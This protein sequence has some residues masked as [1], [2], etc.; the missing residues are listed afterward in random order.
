MRNMEHARVILSMAARNLA[1]N[2]GRTV[3]TLVAITVGLLG[4][5]LLD[6][7]IT[8][9]MNGFRDAIIRSGTGH[10]EVAGAPAYFDA[11]DTNP[12]PFLL[13]NEKAVDAQLRS[14]PGVKDVMPVMTFSAALSDAGT[15]SFVQVAAYPTAQARTLL[16]LRTIAAGSD[17]AP[18]QSG[19]IL[20]G[21]GLARKLNLSP[22]RTVSL[23]ALSK[24]GG[25]NTESYTVV[26]TSSSG[27]AEVDNVSVSMSLADAQSLVGVQTVASLI[28]FLENTDETAAVAGRISRAPLGTALAGLAERTWEQLSPSFR[29]A[30]SLYQLILFVARFIV[31]LVALFSISGT[32]AVSVMERFRELGT[33]R[34]FGTRRGQ[35]L[36]LLMT[37]ALLLGLAGA[38]AGFLAGGGVSGLVNSLGGVPMPPE[39]GMSTSSITI[40]LTPRLSSFFGN[41]LWLLAASLAAALVPGMSAVRKTVRRALEI[42][43]GDD[44]EK[45]LLPPSSSR[46]LF[47]RARTPS[48]RRK[49]SRGPMRTGTIDDLSFEVRLSA[50]DGKE[51][52]DE[53]T[54]WGLL[55]VGAD[56]NRV[57][58][59]FAEPASRP[60]QEAPGGWR[61]RVPPLRANH[62]PHPALTAGSPHGAG[63]ERRRGAHLRA[64]LRRGVHGR[65]RPGRE[66]HLALLPG[67]QRNPWGTRA[68]SGS[69]SG[70]SARASGSS[71]PSSMPHQER[72]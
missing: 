55:K 17:L 10:I 5:T 49:S 62:Q 11:G 13:K 30:N 1:R 19:T 31:L 57:L 33:L 50:Y 44:H 43:L 25:V 6:G 64:G 32:L 53:K 8:Y 67:R 23:F 36:V 72:S 47:P 3:S 29:A 40:S 70:W 20:V 51:V 46:S 58:M 4:L 27:I 26:G 21:T 16:T 14:I 2:R 34:A 37:E 63:I 7:F 52:T 18:G 65:R 38:A 48:L 39:P 59:Y 42:T 22:G 61:C 60:G 9:S 69:S 12:I 41:G 35:V 56:H 24:G 68:T 28:V 71:T 54:L 66:G 45:P 15:T